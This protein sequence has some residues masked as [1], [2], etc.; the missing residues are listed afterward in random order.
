A[1]SI[2][3]DDG[4]GYTTGYVLIDKEVIEVTNISTNTLTLV[5]GQ[6]NTVAATHSSGVT[7]QQCLYYNGETV[8]YIVNDL[9]TNYSNI[10]SSFIPLIEWTSNMSSFGTL[11][12]IVVK[13]TDVNKLLIELTEAIPH[14]LWW[15]ERGTSPYIR[16]TPLS[17]PPDNATT[18][19][20]SSNLIEVSITDDTKARVSTVFIHFGQFDPTKKL[21]EDSNYQQT[22]ARI[23][24]DSIAK[25]GSGEVKEIHSRWLS[26]INLAGAQ[27]AATLIGR[28]F[29]DIQRKISFELDPKDSDGATGLW[30]G[31]S[32]NI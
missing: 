26:N 21:D 27:K 4:S 2:V 24:T 1:T 19:N 28:R 15:D 20:T 11:T 6:F 16:M 10:D 22:W 12:G 25:Y 32:R 3:V 8:P 14:Y 29:S 17:A 5:R 31:Q 18:L 30:T 13:P 23:D 7:V 9:L